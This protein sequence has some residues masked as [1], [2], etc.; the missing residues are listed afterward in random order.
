[1]RGESRRPPRARDSQAMLFDLKGKRRRVVQAT[2]LALA[3]L[4]AVGLVGA[5]I[6]SDAAGGLFDVFQSDGGRGDANK[7]LEQRAERADATVR[8]HPRDEA[9]LREAIRAHYT[10]ASADTDRQTRE[11]GDEGKRE[12]GRAASLWDRYLA[13]KPKDVD[14]A[15]ATQMIFAFDPIGLNRPDK[16]AEAA[17]IVA[18]A[19]DDPDSYVQLVQYAALAGQTRK[20]D[21]AGEKAIDLAP[22]K[23]KREYK[24]L[25]KQAKEP[26]PPGGAPQPGG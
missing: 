18:E 10:L 12:L 14:V 16:A 6:G 26:A 9:A 8:A 17:E 13:L 25:V 24:Q 20:A 3:L 19:R 5:G 22:R 7:A 4:M 1:M 21:L 2:Y 15:L 23:R 11:F